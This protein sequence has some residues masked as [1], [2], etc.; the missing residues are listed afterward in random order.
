RRD[1]RRGA[2]RR[3]GHSRRRMRPGPPGGGASQ[4]AL[5][6]RS[7]HRRLRADHQA[8]ARRVTADATPAA[9]GYRMP[10]E[11]EPHAATWLAWPHER[12]DWPGK[13]APIPWVYAEVVRH[14][15]P[16]ERVCILVQDAAAERAARRV[17]SQAGVDLGRVDFHR[18]PT[19]RS[20]T[21]DFCPLFVRREDGDVALVNWRFNG[22]AKYPNHRRDDAVTD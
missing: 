6:P 15:V 11:W 3:G 9:L 14:L 12:T 16:G 18:V 10:A 22:W 8:P 19:D 4:L 21:R 13:L 7:P 5:P 20:W 2:A 17:L 1:A